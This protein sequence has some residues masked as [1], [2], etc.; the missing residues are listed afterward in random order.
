MNRRGNKQVNDVRQYKVWIR[1]SA[2]RDSAKKPTK[3]LEMKRS[4]NQ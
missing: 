2:N 4:I 1:N 3:I